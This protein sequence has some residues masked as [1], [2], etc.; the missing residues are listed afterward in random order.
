ML[1][2]VGL[3]SWLEDASA[4]RW[5]VIACFG[6]GGADLLALNVAVFPA[7]ADASDP[8]APP[9]AS[10][11]TRGE[12]RASADT[13]PD[14]PAR[15]RASTPAVVAEGA[16][17]LRLGFDSESADLTDDTRRMVDALALELKLD[18]ELGVRLDGYADARGDPF[19]NQDLS[20][21]RAEAIRDRLVA[22]GVEEKRVEVRGLG[23]AGQR[24]D[25]A[26]ADA[27]AS[28]RRV[29]VFRVR[30]RR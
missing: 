28:D 10:G 29:E 11:V 6:L 9:T 15:P 2:R 27:H 1:R 22:G 30:R 26:S 25:D 14:E 24:T 13:T 18:D 20:M 8:A 5:A 7:L 21:R 12:T 3:G 17:F 4:R 23:A 16:P 19:F